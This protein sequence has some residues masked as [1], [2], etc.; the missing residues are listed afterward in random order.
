MFH[1]Q[2]SVKE[3]CLFMPMLQ[4]VA[5]FR[6]AGRGAGS[7]RRSRMQG[8]WSMQHGMSVTPILST[9]EGERR[10]IGGKACLHNACSMREVRERREGREEMF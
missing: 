1:A 10:G 7:K 2:R 9:G 5:A 4:Q 8:V 3:I 6:Q